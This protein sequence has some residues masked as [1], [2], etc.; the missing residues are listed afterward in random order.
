MK[1]RVVALLVILIILFSLLPVIL[2]DEESD[3]SYECLKTKLGTNCG[4]T[5]NTEQAAFS[6]LAMAHDSSIQSDCKSS[7]DSKKK[8][9]NCWGKTATDACSVKS[10]ALAA[11]ALK[12]TGSNVDKS[13]K[14]L[15]DQRRLTDDL[16]WYLQVDTDGESNCSLAVN[17]G[18]P[19]KFTIND[20]KTISNAPTGFSLSDDLYFLKL[21]TN[22]LDKN[23][24]IICDKNFKTS[25]LYKESTTDKTYYVSSKTD[26]ASANDATEEKVNSFCFRNPGT[27]KCDYEGSLWAA[28]AL[29][30]SGKTFSEYIPYITTK[31]DNEENIK[32]LPDAFL[33][34]LMSS[35]NYYSS[36]I[37]KQKYN[38]YWKQGVKNDENYDT[39]LALLTLKGLTSNEADN[40]R[41]YLL[42]KRGTDS[43][44]DNTLNTAFLLYSGWPKEAA[45]SSSDG[46]TL[47]EYCDDAD[48]FCVAPAECAAENLLNMYTCFGGGA[49]VCCKIA[50]PEETCSEKKGIVCE[51]NQECSAN[52]VAA[53]D[54]NNCCLGACLEIQQTTECEKSLYTCKSFCNTETEEEKIG[55]GCNT[56]DVC[57][58]AKAE[59]PTNWFLIILLIVMIILVVLAIIFRNQLKVWWFKIKSKFQK[60]KGPAPTNRPM[61][62]PPGFGGHTAPR[63]IIPRKPESGA[64]NDTMDKLRRMTK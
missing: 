46:T 55:Y 34:M 31:M 12:N 27:A 30:K 63:Q 24:T 42:Q 11:L 18:N 19:S 57:C 17:N 6:L 8:T 23:F 29:A 14:W 44:W 5:M 28:L 59:T 45:S 7:I 50:P 32:Y 52:K 48:Y 47:F 33:Y 15:L 16:I 13:I 51:S 10:T 22:Y 58:S 25:F 62:P 56:G 3:K 38:K 36:L 54:T 26:Y 64:F 41:I 53:G 1:K 21:E 9:D 61:S 49:D 35:D 40:S 4:D 43:C 37:A 60:G 39:A 2:A 20:D